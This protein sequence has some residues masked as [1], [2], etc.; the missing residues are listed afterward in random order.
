LQN[1]EKNLE[2]YVKSLQLE[3]GVLD[4]LDQQELQTLTALDLELGYD[5]RS[6]GV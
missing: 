2:D 6:I 3:E 5:W 4:D 1:G